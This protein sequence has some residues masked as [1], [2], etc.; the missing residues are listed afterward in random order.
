MATFSLPLL[1]AWIDLSLIFALRPGRTSEGSQQFGVPL[2]LGTLGVPKPQTCSHWASRNLTSTVLLPSTGSQ[3][4]SRS[5]KLWASICRYLQFLE[6]WFALCP[7][8]S[9]RSKNSCLF[10]VC[11]IFYLSGERVDF[12]ALY[13][14]DWKLEVSLLLIGLHEL[15]VYSIF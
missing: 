10:S 8:F 9:G 4:G 7:Q 1:Q 5:A 6:Q 12:Q 15:F 13:V 2:R 11:S 14:L 3:R